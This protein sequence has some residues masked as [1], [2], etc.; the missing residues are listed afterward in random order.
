MNTDNLTQTNDV[1]ADYAPLPLLDGY[2]FY[3]FTGTDEDY[4][5]IA[6]VV[7]SRQ[8]ERDF[9]APTT[10]DEIKSEY[11]YLGE[12]CDPKRDLIF[13]KKD[14]QVIAY[15]RGSEKKATEEERWDH[16]MMLNINP[17]V[18]DQKLAHTLLAWCE[19]QASLRHQTHHAGEAADY[20][21]HCLE[22]MPDKMALM[23]E[24]NY[25]PVRYWDTLI[26]RLEDIPH[27][28]MPEGLEL[29]AAMPSHYRQIWEADQEA[30]KDHWGMHEMSEEDY[31][32]WT[33]PKEYFQPYLF[34]VAWD[35]DEIAG[36]V[37]PWIIGPQNDLK[38]RARATIGDVSVRRPWRGKGLAKAL[39]SRTL[40]ALKLLNIKEV[41]L[42]VDSENPSGAY[43]L[44]ETLG[45]V[46]DERGISWRKPLT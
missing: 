13:S 40:E 35:G 6:K 12:S 42:V 7:N 38:K 37:L 27:F 2:R 43:K 29:R 46:F 5:N 45:F 28:P 33:D 10:A 1:P 16:F 8:G 36:E 19:A 25:Q 9:F 11:G 39:L 30:F 4:E 15:C 41:E 23:K 34:Q 21:Y 44:Y 24:A 14:G 26:H 18:S 17:K 3:R 22:Q 32:A 31:Q 20:C